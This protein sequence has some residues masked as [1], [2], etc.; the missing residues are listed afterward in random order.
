MDSTPLS[1]AELLV[2][3][4]ERFSASQTL[5]N[6]YI[7][8]VLG[9]IGFVA[10]VPN[11]LTTWWIRTVVTLGFLAFALVNLNAIGNVQAQRAQ[12]LPTAIE[13]AAPA[14]AQM[15]QAVVDVSAP[16]TRMELRVFHLGI[17]AAVVFLIWFV[18]YARVGD[19]GR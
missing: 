1:T 18:P 4:F 2:M 3:I 19:R 15:V 11:A 16:P 7:T 8:V 5:W 14:D 10:A 17:D 9:V 13:R 6:L 12:L